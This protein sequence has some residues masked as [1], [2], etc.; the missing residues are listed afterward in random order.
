M[1]ICIN[2]TT[3]IIRVIQGK[4]K[5]TCPKTAS[6]KKP[7]LNVTRDTRMILRMQILSYFLSLEGLLPWTADTL[8]KR[9]LA[10]PELVPG[11]Q[12]TMGS[13]WQYPLTP[14]TP[15]RLT[16]SHLRPAP[17]KP[18]AAAQSP[19]LLNSSLTL[20][21]TAYLMHKTLS[22]FINI[23]QHGIP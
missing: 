10:M 18:H 21:P 17:S 15:H 2:S 12:R 4:L 13:S 22:F 9:S 1:D 3:P 7:T 23:S 8:V 11:L 5:E 20:S 14:T 19:Y 6:M 16:D